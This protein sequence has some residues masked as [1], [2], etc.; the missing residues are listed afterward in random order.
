[1]WE[2]SWART[3]STSCFS[4]R[5]QSPVVTA[6]A[7]CFGLRPVANAFGTSRVDDGDPRLRQ[8]GHRAEPLDH[9]VEVG[10]LLGGDD[11]RAGRG[12]R[13]LVG[14]VVLEERHADDDHEHR[15]EPDAQHA[16]EDE[17]ED[18]V[19][20]PE[21]RAREEHPQRKPSIA[22]ERPAVHDRRWYSGGPSYRSRRRRSYAFIRVSPGAPDSS[23][24]RVLARRFAL[25]A[26]QSRGVASPTP[27]TVIGTVSTPTTTFPIVPPSITRATRRRARR[28]STANCGSL[29]HAADA[30]T[31]GTVGPNLDS[32]EAGLPAAT[33]QVT[34]GGATCRR[35]RPALDQQIADV[36]AY[37]VTATGGTPRRP[38]GG[39]PAAT[40]P[41]SPS[42]STGR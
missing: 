37:V 38:S 24:R 26:C 42:I 17:R 14:G 31:T 11:L 7:A 5:C 36:A 8:V 28:S 21:Q 10:R 4:S 41:L 33:A 29:P 16:E 40:S 1:M 15:P 23:H 13:E 20:Q 19:E 9:R 6:T 32:T 18:D 35:S 27:E 12:E 25:A 30:S 39:L 34:N 3:A 2:S 22:T